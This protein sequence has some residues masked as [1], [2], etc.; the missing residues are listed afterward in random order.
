MLAGGE[1]GDEFRER[2]GPSHSQACAHCAQRRGERQEA[3]AEWLL[4][5]REVQENIQAEGEEE[6][7]EIYNLEDEALD[8]WEYY[9][10]A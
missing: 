7:E 4:L 9:M 1:Q 3:G 2:R 8:E 10:H 6:F 5:V